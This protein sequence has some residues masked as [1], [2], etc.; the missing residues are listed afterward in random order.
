MI[1]RIFWYHPFYLYDYYGNGKYTNNTPSLVHTLPFNEV[2][3]ILLD[4]P[5]IVFKST[6]TRNKISYTKKR[7]TKP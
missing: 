5:V 4:N 1:V 7:R 3:I 2:I 6:L